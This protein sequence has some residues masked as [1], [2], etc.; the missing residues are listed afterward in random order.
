M[1]HFQIPEAELVFRHVRASGP[2]GQNVNKVSTA[3]EL[4]FDIGA[5]AS[6]PVEVKARLRRIAGRRVSGEDVLV[7][8][9]GRF[10]TQEAN[11]RDALAR[12]A[13]LLRVASVKPKA[14]IAT[15]PTRAS[16]ERRIARKRTRSTLK[17]GR[18]PVSE[19]D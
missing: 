4:R 3:V 13:E 10:R 11:R 6:L 1:R 15:R 8:D 18:G 2:G 19:T 9:A 14:R 12:L 7:I 5:S 16:K 17:R